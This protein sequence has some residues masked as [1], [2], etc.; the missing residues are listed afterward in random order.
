[1]RLPKPFFRLPVRIDAERLRAEALSLPAS[2]WA[3]HPNHVAGNSAARLISVDG[4]ENDDVNGV[5][6]VTPHLAQLPYTRQVLAGFGVVW[7]R[8]R[9][10]R[11]APGAIVPQHADINYHWF[12]RVRLHIPVI[13]RPEVRFYCGDQSVHM[14]GG[15]AWVF[16]NWRQHRVEN[17]TPDERIHLVADT[18]GSAAFWQLVAQGEARDA[19][20]HDIAFDPSRDP[21]VLTERTTLAPVMTPG[22]VDLLVNDLRAELVAAD[23]SHDTR[24]Q[25]M[26]YHTLLDALCRD[27]R[28]LYA[29]HGAEASGWADFTR[30]RD[31]VRSTSRSLAAGIVIRTNRV[32]AHS[33]LEGRVLRAMLA[34]PENQE[35]RC[36]RLSRRAAEEASLSSAARRLRASSSDSAAHTPL[37]RPV[38]IVAAPRSGSTLLFETLAVSRH[39]CTIGGEGHMLV[40]GM[41]ELQ[42]GAPG[43]ESNR[44]VAE[45]A[46]PDAAQ[47]IRAQILANLRDA[48]GRPVPADSALRFL[49]KT[50]K[51]ALRIPFFNAVFPDARFI[52]LWR[53]PQENLGS[54]IDAWGSGRWKTYNGLPGFDGPWSLLLPPGWKSLNGKPME[55]IAAAQWDAA[56]R[57]VLDDLAALPANRW[58][59]VHYADLIAHPARTVSRLCAFLG[60][61]PDDALTQRI[62]APLPPSRYTLGPPQPGKW[63]KHQTEVERVL[64]QVTP[65]WERLKSLHS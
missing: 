22:E 37:D 53:D 42:P 59:A 51:N 46:T 41:P 27:W 2:A 50:P 33:V 64:P 3:Q 11:L 54:I 26:R 12:N 17:P 19:R 8:S 21:Q 44:L 48:S 4:G 16:D 40:E 10:L 30:V 6:G 39:L 9:F 62:S 25:L 57:T 43:V 34:L 14:A 15:E 47:R 61:E 24:L 36:A 1:M 29:L 23:D 18:S 45:H 38:F 58:T 35:A 63:R 31:T 56:N 20:I 49:E 13:T 65:T 32:T 52:F 28:Q 60:F 5:M 7:S 55:E